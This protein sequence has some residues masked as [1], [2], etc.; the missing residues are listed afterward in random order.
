[1]STSFL[2]SA[3][4]S[5]ANDKAQ[6]HVANVILGFVLCS[7]PFFR[8]KE[9]ANISVLDT[10]SAHVKLIQGNNILREVVSNMIIRAKFTADRFLRRQQIGIACLEDIVKTRD[11]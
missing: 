9:I 1:M 10:I 6:H 2:S 5:V 8:Q 11:Y 3:G 4:F 7:V